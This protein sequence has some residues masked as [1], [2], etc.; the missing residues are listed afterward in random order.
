MSHRV[1]ATDG[2][3]RSVCLESQPDLAGEWGREGNGSDGSVPS[4]SSWKKFCGKP[5]GAPMVSET[6]ALRRGR[7]RVPERTP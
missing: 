3:G 1:P 5:S 4:P 6:T 7:A 2:G